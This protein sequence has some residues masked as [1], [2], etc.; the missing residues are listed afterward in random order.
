M[1]TGSTELASPPVGETADGHVRTVGIE[2]EFGRLTAAEA[3]EAVASSFGPGIAAEAEDRH[4]FRIAPPEGS[5]WQGAF[6]VELD[7]RWAHP[8][9]VKQYAPE[10]PEDLADDLPRMAAEL[11]GEVASLVMPVELVAPPLPWSSMRAIDP[12]VRAL[13]EAGATGTTHSSFAGFGMHLNVECA[14]LDAEYLLSVLRA[15]VLIAP[16]LRK[17]SQL[18]A[19]RRV[20]SYIDPF[21]VE[22]A[23]HVLARDYAPDLGQLIDDYIALVPT[24]NMELDM[25]PVFAHLDGE[26]VRRRLPGAKIGARPTF[27]WRLP[28][29]RIDEPDWDPVADWNRWVRVENL[30]ADARELS[31]LARTFLAKGPRWEIEARMGRILDAF[32]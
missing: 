17:E 21:T 14:R 24:R 32:E 28:D 20:Q 25:L 2:L 13:R 1:S 3:A 27:H 26:R 15:Y 18:A 6:E 4:R 19:I 12:I 8:D 31:V 9:H 22:F 16:R 7:T 11:W 30:A 10:L 5:C 29:C 23:R